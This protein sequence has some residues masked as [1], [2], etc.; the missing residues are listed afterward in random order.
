MS[1][2]ETPEETAKKIFVLTIIGT[3][4][5]VGAVVVYVMS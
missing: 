2:L 5:Y 4:L 3:V 1:D